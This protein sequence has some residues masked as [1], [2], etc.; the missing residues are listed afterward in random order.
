MAY[1]TDVLIAF[2]LISMLRS[3]AY[4]VENTSGTACNVQ[5]WQQL[6]VLLIGLQYLMLKTVTYVCIKGEVH[7]LILN[8]VQ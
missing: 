5:Y 7:S 4:G 8:R 6:G 3:C 1:S 2:S